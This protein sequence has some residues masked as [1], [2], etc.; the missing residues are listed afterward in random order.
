M[1]FNGYVCHSETVH[2][3]WEAFW[4]KRGKRNPDHPEY[5]EHLLDAVVAYNSM[6]L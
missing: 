5:A 3:D 6:H 1:R 2:S 4:I